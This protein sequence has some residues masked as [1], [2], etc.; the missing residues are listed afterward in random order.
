[1]RHLGICVAAFQLVRSRFVVWLIV[2]SFPRLACV[3]H[4]SN[5]SVLPCHL[6]RFFLISQELPS[7]ALTFRLVIGCQTNVT[8]PAIAESTNWFCTRTVKKPDGT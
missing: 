4:V 2:V 6:V 7:T 1:M 8:V 5:K 3:H